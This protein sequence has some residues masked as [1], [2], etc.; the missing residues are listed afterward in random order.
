MA[1]SM[2]E[3]KEHLSLLLL[4]RLGHVRLPS[5]LTEWE[6]YAGTSIDEWHQDTGSKAKAL[7]LRLFLTVV[8]L[9]SCAFVF[10]NR[11]E[12]GSLRS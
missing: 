1:H 9:K 4:H 2:E 6:N 7:F 12:P 3:F 11:C 8:F 5:G 10:G